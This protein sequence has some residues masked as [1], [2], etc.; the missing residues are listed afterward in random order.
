MIV[1]QSL[2]GWNGS[3]RAE[4]AIWVLSQYSRGKLLPFR[5]DEALTSS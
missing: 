5:S 3:S 4:N 1:L 2:R